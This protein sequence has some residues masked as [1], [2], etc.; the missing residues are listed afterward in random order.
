MRAVFLDRDGVINKKMPEGEYVTSPEQFEIIDGALEAIKS[1]KDAGFLVFVITNQRGIALGKMTPEQLDGIHKILLD[2]LTEIGAT[3]D[4]IYVCPHDKDTCDCRKPK[5]GLILK[6]KRDYP[7]ID[8]P[9][10]I[11][12]GD[13]NS[14]IETGKMAGCGTKILIGKQAVSVDATL[15]IDSLADAIKVL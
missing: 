10:S 5:P 8:L 2:K 12:I 6:I 9:G 3:L 13:T 7:E 15:F 4:G 11:V 1:F 14:D